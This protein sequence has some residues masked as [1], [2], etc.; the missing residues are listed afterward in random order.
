MCSGDVNDYLFY[1]FSQS[2]PPPLEEIFGR[3]DLYSIGEPIWA[4]IK[5]EDMWFPSI[6]SEKLDSVWRVVVIEPAWRRAKT[7]TK[8]RHANFRISSFIQ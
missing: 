5:E 2:D 1:P 4:F 7:L 3:S 6:I 8:G